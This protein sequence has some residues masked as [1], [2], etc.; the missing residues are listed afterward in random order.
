M[1]HTH[2]RN[3]EAECDR[4]ETMSGLPMMGKQERADA[5]AD[6]WFTV[7]VYIMAVCLVGGAIYAV[8]ILVTP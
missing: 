3:Y 4:R 1:S 8:A 7:L 2:D 5:W 6:R